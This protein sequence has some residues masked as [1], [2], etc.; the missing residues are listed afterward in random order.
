MLIIRVACPLIRSQLSSTDSKS[1]HRFGFPG[2]PEAGARL[3]AWEG[4]LEA[5]TAQQSSEAVTLKQ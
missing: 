2:R 1:V 4:S 3:L 5:F